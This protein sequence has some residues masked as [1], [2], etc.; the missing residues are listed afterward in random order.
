VRD[1]LYAPDVARAVLAMLAAPAPA[2][3]L[4]NVSFP[5]TYDLFDWAM[6]LKLWFPALEVRVAGPGEPANV[7]AHGDRSRTPLATER[8]AGDLGVRAAFG[9]EGSAEHYAR[10]AIAH[11]GVLLGQG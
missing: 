2:H 7:Q 10:W 11:R 6:H 1:W 8:L 3:D 9:L 4:H 5:A